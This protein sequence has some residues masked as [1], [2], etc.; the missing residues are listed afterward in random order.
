VLNHLHPR[1]H[2]YRP[3][4]LDRLLAR[5]RRAGHKRYGRPGPRHSGPLD[6]RPHREGGDAP[7]ARP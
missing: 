1:H 3:P 6:R 5:Q 4:L 7:P 2:R